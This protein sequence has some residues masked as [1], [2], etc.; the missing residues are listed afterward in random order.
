[1]ENKDYIFKIH[2]LIDSKKD[3]EEIFSILKDDE[4]LVDKFKSLSIMLND[5]KS[6]KLEKIPY[7]IDQKIIKKIKTQRKKKTFSLSLSFGLTIIFLIVLLSPSG[8]KKQN[9][10]FTKIF[11]KQYKYTISNY[12]TINSINNVEL[13]LYVKGDTIEEKSGSLKIPKEDFDLLFET[14]NEKGDLIVNKIEGD[15]EKTDYINIKINYKN[16]PKLS[17]ISFI[18]YILPYIIFAIILIIPLPF[19]LRSLKKWKF[20]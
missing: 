4:A 11:N 14:L 8:Y 9:N 20:S 13:T 19:L 12:V 18:G 5:L 7:K 10:N 6:L 16:Y 17:I 2:E 1:M 3:K 15:G